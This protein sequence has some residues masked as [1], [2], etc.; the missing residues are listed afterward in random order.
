MKKI[1][2]LSVLALL[3]CACDSE[4]APTKANTFDR[5]LAHETSVIA[6]E[7]EADDT[8]H[9]DTDDGD[10]KTTPGC[11]KE[12]NDPIRCFPTADAVYRDKCDEGNLT[13]YAAFKD[14]A[15]TKVCAKDACC[16]YVGS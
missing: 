9:E 2:P 10:D 13:E 8:T 6:A 11:V 14:D 4:P 1:A 5:I 16:L 15:L 3:A 7:L 12:Y